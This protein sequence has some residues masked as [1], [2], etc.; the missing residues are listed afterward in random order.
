MLQEAEAQLVKTAFP[1]D[2]IE[3]VIAA[4]Q[5]RPTNHVTGTSVTYEKKVAAADAAA[6]VAA[7]SPAYVRRNEPD[8]FGVLLAFGTTWLTAR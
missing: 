5:E 3:T 8:Q 1:E 7:Q 2:T 4:R 6:M